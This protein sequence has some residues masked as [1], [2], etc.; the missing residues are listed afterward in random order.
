MQIFNIYFIFNQK[1]IHLQ[2]N[3]I[4]IELNVFVLL[5]VC[6][7]KK[8]KRFYFKLSPFSKGLFSLHMHLYVQFKYSPV[9]A[10]KSGILYYFFI[11]SI[12][13]INHPFDH[14]KPLKKIKFFVREQK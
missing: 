1:K 11:F 3:I 12:P 13:I 8:K 6:R 14:K 10:L 4:H 9:V 5:S 2:N 7:F